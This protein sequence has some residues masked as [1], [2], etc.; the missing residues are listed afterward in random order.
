MSNSA[1]DLTKGLPKPASQNSQEDYVFTPGGPRR[2]S[3]VHHIERGAIVLNEGGRLKQY[4]S[5]RRL[6]EDFGVAEDLSRGRPHVNRLRNK[7][8][9]VPGLGHGWIAYVAWENDTGTPI[10][11][12][13][14]TWVVP[15]APLSQGSQIVYLFN[16]LENSNR[17]LQPVLQWGNDGYGGGS[18]WTIASWYAGNEHDHA[19]HSD[20]VQ[21]EPGFVLEGIMTLTAQNGASFDYVCEFQNVPGTSLT[22]Q[23]IQELTSAYETLEAY[24][25]KRASNYPTRRIQMAG[26]DLRL[27]TAPA[28]LAW[29][30]I[31]LVTD[32][33]QR[34]IVIDAS[35]SGSGEVDIYC[36]S[37]KY[38][39][40]IPNPY[41]QFNL[42]YTIP[43]DAVYRK[44]I[45][46][47]GEWSVDEIIIQNAYARQVS[48]VMTQQVQAQF[49][50]V[51]YV[52]TNSDLYHDWQV[53][54]VGWL[55]ESRV[56]GN[57]TALQLSAVLNPNGLVE[58][59]YVGTNTKI[60]HNWQL[61]TGGWHGE[62]ALGGFAKQLLAIANEDGHLE[63]IYIGTNGALYHNWQVEPTGDWY[64]ETAFGGYAVQ[65]AA[66]KNS[67]QCIEIVY[68]GTNGRLYF[69]RQT[70][71]NNGW[72]G[73]QGLV[74]SANRIALAENHSGCLEL[75]YVGTNGQLYCNRQI[76]PTGPWGAEAP[77]YCQ[78][79]DVV[80]GRDPRE[81]LT[82]VYLGSDGLLYYI[83][84][85][86]ADGRWGQQQYL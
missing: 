56:G 41:D 59:F 44:W 25:I 26:I 27:G 36:Y 53:Q 18:Y 33:G 70:A 13:N 71:P 82:I 45:V 34:A 61:S 43:D 37:V 35:S 21:V 40:A 14:T 10:T 15:Q 29:D 5:S 60:Y 24:G 65:F 3:Y 79:V 73:E 83:P 52:G 80:V 64:G 42:F 20:F 69:N 84:Q 4:D 72:T 74:G 77:L 62:A 2:R 81:I 28:P 17:I 68:I 55:G 39:T 48:G 38:I 9:N 57:A 76:T 78:A 30:P 12:F 47:G 8:E 22:V 6:I 86:A 11:S 75:V 16:G 85:T 7:A 51:Y 46:G 23:G 32:T 54:G 63:L 66:Y 50:D 49:L 19:F 58:I 1:D 67:S 31:D